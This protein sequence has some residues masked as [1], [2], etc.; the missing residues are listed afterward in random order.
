MAHPETF[1]DSFDSTTLVTSSDV[2]EYLPKEL[3]K[4]QLANAIPPNTYNEIFSSDDWHFKSIEYLRMNEPRLTYEK[5][6]QLDMM[7]IKDVKAA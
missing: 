7:L 6:C 3:Y 5:I 1:N 4:A 2:S